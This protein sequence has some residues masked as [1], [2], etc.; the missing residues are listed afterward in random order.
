MESIEGKK[1]HK[2]DTHLLDQPPLPALLWAFVWTWHYPSAD[3][4]HILC[5][6][7]SFLLQQNPVSWQH[8][9]KKEKTHQCNYT[10]NVTAHFLSRRALNN[11]LSSAWNHVAIFVWFLATKN[12]HIAIGWSGKCTYINYTDLS[13]TKFFNVIDSVSFF[14]TLLEELIIHWFVWLNEKFFWKENNFYAY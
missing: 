13:N 14:R 6:C 12:K 5:T 7:P 8:A 11:N 10:D 4:Q 1:W 9:D 2:F 3:K